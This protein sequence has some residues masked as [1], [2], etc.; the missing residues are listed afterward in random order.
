MNN[1]GTTSVHKISRA[2]AISRQSSQHSPSSSL[3][4]STFLKE[5]L[6]VLKASPDAGRESL[7]SQMEKLIVGP[8]GATH[9]PALIIIDALDEYKDKQPASAICLQL[10]TD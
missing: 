1:S 8:L 4:V 7:C 10:W 6:P 5:L 3:S 2:E 9:T